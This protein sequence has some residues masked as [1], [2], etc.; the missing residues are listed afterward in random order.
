M[1]AKL[2]ELDEKILHLNGEGKSLRAI[3]STLSISHEAVRKR[4]KSIEGKDRMSSNMEDRRLTASTI[5]KENVSTG[6]KTHKSKA[7][8]RPKQPV[9][10]VST[11]K[12]PSHNPAE[13]VN[14]R[15][16]LAE[17]PTRGKKGV[18]Q[19]VC[20][21][22]DDLFG[23]I[24]DFLESKGIE[25]YRMQNGGYQVKGNR[26]IVRFYITRR[27]SVKEEMG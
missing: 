7:P 23:A 11:S 10:R 2:N 17:Q 21:R 14:P 1:K 19:E 22:I 13:G 3:A 8:R 15:E 12:A 25:V 16:T 27:D 18:S 5:K 4:L 9:N 6:S 20:S 26:E 24:K